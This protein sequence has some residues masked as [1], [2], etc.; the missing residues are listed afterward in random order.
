MST[1]VKNLKWV[2][3]MQLN[4]NKKKRYVV[5]FNNSNPVYT[6]GS[7]LVIEYAKDEKAWLNS[8]SGDEIQLCSINRYLELPD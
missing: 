6:E 8:D 3:V 7:M 1:S 5:E 2:K 4:L